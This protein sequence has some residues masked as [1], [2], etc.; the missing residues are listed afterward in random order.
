[1]LA[2]K[3][4]TS[5]LLYIDM[6]IIKATIQDIPQL[7]KL[8]NSAYR[9]NESRKGWTTEAD[10]LEGKRVDAASLTAI[11]KDANSVILKHTDGTEITGCVYLKKN[12]NKMYLGMLTV[13]PILQTAGL[14]KKI[15]KA[16][17]EYAVKQG[18]DTVEMRV[19]PL[20]VELIDW[21]KR[22]GYYDTGI[23]IPYP[24]DDTLSIQLK[25]VVF[26]MLEK[27]L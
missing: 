7:E 11:M 10:F 1:M 18:C 19:I 2:I 22:R 14:G 27:K 5:W 4:F 24:P 25:P 17:E 12:D 13:S 26:T 23:I 8:I 15:L 20:R 9:G 6:E 16:S 3:N 21:Y